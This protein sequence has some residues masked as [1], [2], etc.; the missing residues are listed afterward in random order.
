MNAIAFDTHEAVKQLRDSG[1]EEPQA[2]AIVKAVSNNA[3][4]QVDG[5]ATKGDLSTVRA[6]LEAAIEKS[7]N[8][9]LVSLYGGLAALGAIII[10][11]VKFL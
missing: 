9:L 10:A 3:R 2:E 7:K 6:E 1:F 5:L 11:A 8:S 4:S